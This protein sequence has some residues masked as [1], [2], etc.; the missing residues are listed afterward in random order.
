MAYKTPGKEIVHTHLSAG[1]LGDSLGTL[2]DG[3]LGELT[4]KDEPDSS[5]DFPGGKRTLVAI[6]DKIAT[7]TSNAVEG[8][9]NQVVQD[10]HRLLADTSLGVHLLEYPQDVGGI[11]LMSLSVDLLTGLLGT[12]R[13]L[14]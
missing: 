10:S 8:I 12:G 11:R 3:V 9:V 4:R 2:R 14:D 13:F 7:F 5:L 6:A 1:E